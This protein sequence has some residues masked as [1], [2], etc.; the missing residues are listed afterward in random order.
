MITETQLDAICNL[1]LSIARK[2]IYTYID[3][4]TANQIDQDHFEFET[5]EG[6][7]ELFLCFEDSHS[8]YYEV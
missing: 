6:N 4:G 3:N 5:T 1:P 7:A 2:I 8:F